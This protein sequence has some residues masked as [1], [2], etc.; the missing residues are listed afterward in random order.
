VERPRLIPLEAQA[1]TLEDGSSGVSLRDPLGVVRSV[2]TLSP[3]AWWLV[4]R[5]DG[6][7][8]P[9]EIAAEAAE[10]GLAVA[11]AEVRKLAEG[12][13]RA[14]FLE[15]P[16]H[17]ALRRGALDAFRALGARP[18]SCAGGVYPADAAAL[19][20][21]LDGW[22][23]AA[24]PAPASAA[25]VRLLVAPHIDYHRGGEGYARA[26]R[27]LAG[28]DADLFVVFGTA[29]ASPRRLFTATRLDYDTPLGPV[30]TDRGVVDALA[31]AVGDE[32]FD[33]ELAHRDE[34]SCELQ[35][36]WLRHVL[37]G[38]AFSAVPVLCSSIAH[39][40]DPAAAV[41]RFL[42]ALARAVEGRRVCYV[43]A[44][45]LA[46]VGPRYGDLRPPTAGELA[47]LEGEDRRTL[48]RLAAG[49]AAA[50]HR[51]AARDDA[52][53]R[54]CGIAPIYAAMRAS[55]AGARL[56]HYAQWTDGTDSVSYAAAAG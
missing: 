23:A 49:D 30:P 54:I 26:Y 7:R 29:H 38:R 9:E 24:P 52:R 46:H 42:E 27:A 37:G 1:A 39:L 53:R 20:R 41:D 6:R 4:A 25:P 12:L 45:D 31:R 36:P 14:G 13:G 19:R 5:F 10:E 17:E 8:T 21:A 34:H 28:T 44:A 11:P 32:L 48:G 22:L 55:G 35:M 2:A 16:A 33:D 43:A 40:D 18:P 51:D 47:A 56:L 50:F 3:A 15:G